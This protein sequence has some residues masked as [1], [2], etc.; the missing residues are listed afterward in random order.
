[1]LTAFA[2]LIVIVAA[3][4]IKQFMTNIAEPIN[5]ADNQQIVAPTT[6]TTT[7][8][9]GTSTAPA[10]Q[11]GTTTTGSSPT[12]GSGQ[13]SPS[14]TPSTS[15]SAPPATKLT[16][17]NATVYD[18]QGTPPK[19]Y[20]SYVDLAY[21]GDF[22]TFWRTWVYKQQFGRAQ[23]GLKDGVGLVLNMGKAVTPSS[24]TVSTGTAGTTVEIRSASSANPALESTQVLGSASLGADPVTIT[25]ANP[26]KSQYLILWI[27]H[28]APYQGTNAKNVG[29]FQ[30]SITEISVTGS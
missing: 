7:R 8:T 20:E 24:V 19:D 16:I 21:D 22:S 15:S 18:P 27:T 28:L 30:S 9:V 1:M 2:A 3:A 13:P 17:A 10:T 23:G 14:T 29:Q 26:P 6:P 5:A 4:V 11:G 25:L 12:A